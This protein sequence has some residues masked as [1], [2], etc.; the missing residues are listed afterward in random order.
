[1]CILKS[2]GSEERVLL[3]ERK[4]DGQD[5]R[6]EIKVAWMPEWQDRSATQRCRGGAETNG[7]TVSS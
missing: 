6:S 2:P 7:V 4:T 1:M 3:S 5:S